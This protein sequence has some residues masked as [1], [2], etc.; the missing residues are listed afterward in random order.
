MVSGVDAFG[1]TVVR[2]AAFSSSLGAANPK[3]TC[4]FSLRPSGIASIARSLASRLR[5]LSRDKWGT[6]SFA[7]TTA[8]MASTAPEG[9][10]ASGANTG[11]GANAKQR[12]L[13]PAG[14]KQ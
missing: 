12:T 2:A 9:A 6:Q 7:Y 5:T 1:A 4:R 14:G 11:G 13:T 3:T 10:T 8:V